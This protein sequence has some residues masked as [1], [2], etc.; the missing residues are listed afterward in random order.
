MTNTA[1][2]KALRQAKKANIIQKF[3]IDE[4]CDIY[5]TIDGSKFCLGSTTDSARLY[6]RMQQYNIVN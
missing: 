1:I 3:T 4:Y 2:L 6:P 5:V